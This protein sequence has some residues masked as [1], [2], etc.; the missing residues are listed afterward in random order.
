[1]KRKILS[2]DG[3]GIKGIYAASFLEEL[4]KHVPEGKCL[5]DYFDIIAG[6]STGAII[7]A[8][9]AVGIPVKKCLDMYRE[10]GKEIFPPRPAFW[11]LLFPYRTEPLKRNLESV[12]GD[13][14]LDDCRTRLEI[15]TYNITENY[16]RILKTRHYVDY[17][18]DYKVRIVD[19]LLATTAAPTFFLPH[20]FSEDSY[21]NKP[22]SYI[23]GGVGGNNPSIF[24]LTEGI[25]RLDWPIKDMYMLSVSC[26][27]HAKPI[28]RNLRMSVFSVP[29]LIDFYMGAENTYSENTCH[30][31]LKDRFYRIEARKLNRNYRMDYAGKKELEEMIRLGKKSADMFLKEQL[32]DKRPGIIETFLDVPAESYK[33]TCL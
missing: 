12:F 33:E 25:A 19:A 16:A 3:G 7:A 8:G 2:I 29:K 30:M 14:I 20:A 27:P 22:Y 11:H 28:K 13:M 5:A 1:M 21:G 23:D 24:A 9:I 17:V 15:P 32:E 4:E 10:K 18:R 6:T 31:I 26:L